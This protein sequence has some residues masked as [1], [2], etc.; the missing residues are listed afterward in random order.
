VRL[1][2]QEQVLDLRPATV[3]QV[4]VDDPRAL[5]IMEAALFPKTGPRPTAVVAAD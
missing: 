3:A 1:Q 4:D 5:E 2:L